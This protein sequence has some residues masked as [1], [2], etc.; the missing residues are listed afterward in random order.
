MV[1]VTKKSY[2]IVDYALISFW[3]IKGRRLFWGAAAYFS[4]RVQDTRPIKKNV[5][6][7]N[8]SNFYSEHWILSS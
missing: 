6:T 8:E 3:L 1:S 7:V 4:S 2:Q 5:I